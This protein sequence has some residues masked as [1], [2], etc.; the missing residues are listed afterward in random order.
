[1][2][3][4]TARE[5]IT[6]A[7]RDLGICSEDESP[8]AEQMS[9]GLDLL[10]DMMNG[11][12]AKGIQYTHADLTIG[13]TVNVPD[14]LTRSTR[15][16]IAAEIAG[17]HGKQMTPWQELQVMEARQ[18][19]QG[20]YTTVPRAQIDAGVEGRRPPGGIWDITRG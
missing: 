19:L 20:Y 9:Q 16:M 1:M 7:Y 12:E 13:A 14:F 6:A 5:I 8:T 18:E 17:K 4:R 2:A 10:N 3:T 11:W 15:W